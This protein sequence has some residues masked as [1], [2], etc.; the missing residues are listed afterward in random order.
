MNYSGMGNIMI[1]L[2]ISALI[3]LNT[4]ITS[5]YERK[6]EIAVYTS[7]GMAP[8][9]VSFLFIAEAIAFA[10]I[11]VVVGYLIAQTASGLLA[12]TPLWQA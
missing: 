1:P 2:I 3:V 9:H 6:K 7:I 10:V 5:V 8:T 4:M 11:S 12:G